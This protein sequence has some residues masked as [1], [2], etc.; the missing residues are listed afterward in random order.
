MLSPNKPPTKDKKPQMQITSPE[1][2]VQFKN[3]LQQELFPVIESAV[4]PL[5]KEGRLLTAIVSMQPLAR[6]VK[7]RRSHTGRPPSDRVRLATAFFA[8]TIF[9]IATVPDLI[10]RLL[11]DIQ[12][13]RLCGFE[14]A[15]QIPSLST[16]S[17]AFAEFAA[18]EL[19]TQIHAALVCETQQTRIIEHIARDSTAIE[20]RQRLR[21]DKPKAKAA[22]QP[23][24]HAAYRTKTGWH[25]RGPR[26][27]KGPHPRAKAIERGL[28][29]ERQQHM[30]LKEMLADLP[31]QCALG[32]KKNSKGDPQYW[33]GFKLH[34]DVADGGRIP[35]SCILTSAS[36][37]DS[38]VAIPLM[39]LS[40]QRVRWRCELMDSAY[41][42]AL[43]RAQSKKLDHT[44]LI[45]P[46]PSHPRSL[47]ENAFSEEDKQRF[48]K[49]TI[50][51]QLN[52]RLKDEFGGRMIYVRG[53][54]KVMAHLMFGV[55]A[56]TVDQLL[57]LS[58]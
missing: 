12:I 16:F 54:A 17:R 46:N 7:E 34:W 31:Q 42:A 32:A 6:F 43:I 52:A 5:S 4:G 45:Q 49:R 36:V 41:D 30:T 15:D 11:T 27:K 37:H 25:R 1:L 51:E 40:A 48:K 47:R 14:R 53:A 24:A 44:A 28:R 20:A 29:L 22:A 33:R 10:G 18:A 26:R 38:Q 50:V 39:Q 8:K 21:E 55:V 58:G 35:I 2:L 23:P 57:R 3:L 19:P 9:R 56:I 13:R